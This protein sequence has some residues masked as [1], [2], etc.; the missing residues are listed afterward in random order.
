MTA[1]LELVLPLPP[2]VTAVTVKEYVLVH[3][4]KLDADLPIPLAGTVMDSTLPSLP[5]AVMV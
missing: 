3:K 1:T 5:V 2:L 4:S